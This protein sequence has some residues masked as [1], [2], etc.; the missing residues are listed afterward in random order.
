MEKSLDSGWVPF[1][2]V[3]RGKHL[4][5]AENPVHIFMKPVEGPM[6]INI[7]CNQGKDGQSGCKTDNIYK[8]IS[9]V[10]NEVSKSD[11]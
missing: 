6:K 10:F 7:W 4:D 8:W 5:N 3:A 2:K 9:L 1:I 11:F